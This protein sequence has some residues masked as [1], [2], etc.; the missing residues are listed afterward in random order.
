MLKNQELV[1]FYELDWIKWFE[2]DILKT[3]EE[4]NNKL[5]YTLSMVIYENIKLIHF[6]AMLPIKFK[7]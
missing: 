4:F 5:L 6:I 3:F 2:H 1:R 7:K